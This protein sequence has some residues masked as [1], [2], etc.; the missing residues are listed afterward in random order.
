VFLLRDILLLIIKGSHLI[1][2]DSSKE[3]PVISGEAIKKKGGIGV[4]KRELFERSEFSRFSRLRTF[5]ALEEP[6]LIFFRFLFFI[7]RKKE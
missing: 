5:S 3:K 2:I 6:D 1:Y 7:K 4:K